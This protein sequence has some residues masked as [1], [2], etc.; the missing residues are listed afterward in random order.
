MATRSG[1]VDPGLVLW[2][3][4]R[5][6]I[7]AAE[8]SCALEHESGL[9]G[10]AGTGDMRQILSRAAAAATQAEIRLR[11]MEKLGFLG[12]R[13]DEERN[14]AGT[15]DRDIGAPGA[16]ARSLVIGARED[17]EIA[18]QVREVMRADGNR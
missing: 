1:S 12:V 17:L 14:A 18:R 15:G 2:L 8:L 7:P 6:G 10:L 16:L 3:E 11:A 13:A 5:A 4:T 9:Y